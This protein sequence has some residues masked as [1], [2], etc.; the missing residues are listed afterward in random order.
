MGYIKRNRLTTQSDTLLE[1]SLNKH[2]QHLIE[3]IHDSLMCL[4]MYES[5]FQGTFIRNKLQVIIE[6]KVQSS[7]VYINEPGCDV[8]RC[9]S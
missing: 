8:S 6:V 4:C 1:S 7:N 5:Y 9:L 2:S 3:T